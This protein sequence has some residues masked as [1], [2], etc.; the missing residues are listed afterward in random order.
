MVKAMKIGG[1]MQRVQHVRSSV[2]DLRAKVLGFT[3]F[4]KEH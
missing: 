2:I 4:P 1:I 3:Y